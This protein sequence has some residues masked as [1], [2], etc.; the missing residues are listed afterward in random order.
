MFRWTL[1]DG[2]GSS[3]LARLPKIYPSERGFG[4]PRH[5]LVPIHFTT[6]NQ[7]SVFFL[8]FMERGVFGS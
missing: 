5:Y 8:A 3:N 2:S 4:K 6:S 7:I 1:V